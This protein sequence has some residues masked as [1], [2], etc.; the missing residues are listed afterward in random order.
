MALIQSSGEYTIKETGVKQPYTFEFKTFS[1][2]DEALESLGE[3]KVLALVQR[4]VKVD[5]NNTAREKAKTV[6]GHSTKV[7]MSEEQKAEK[8]AQRGADKA[9]NAVF[10]D[11]SR[12]E[13]LAL[14]V[15]AEVLDQL[16]IQ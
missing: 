16:N 1:T 11:K 7:V 4:M 6:N 5:A 8:K 14:G 13:L 9:L 2:I 12:S 3:V 10:K 15:S